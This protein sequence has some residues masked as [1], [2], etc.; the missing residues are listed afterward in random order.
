MILLKKKNYLRTNETAIGETIEI[1]NE[2]TEIKKFIIDGKST[3]DGEPAPDTPIEIESVG[4]TNLFDKD[5]VILENRYLKDDGSTSD[6]VADWIVTMSL[7]EV[8]PNQNYVIS[9]KNMGERFIYAEYS[10]NNPVTTVGQRVEITPVTSFKTSS[11]TKYI[12]FCTNNPNATKF[13]IEE[14]SIVHPYMPYI[15]LGKYGIE[16]KTVGKNLFNNIMESGNINSSGVNYNDGNSIRSVDFIK[17]QP[18]K[19]YTISNNGVPIQCN[20][21]QY[22][23]KQTFISRTFSNA[24]SIIT[25]SNTKYIKFQTSVVTNYKFQLE[26]GSTFTE[27]EPYKENISVLQLNEPLRSL[28]NGV[29]D[30]AYLKNDKLYVDRYVGSVVLNGSEYCMLQSINSYGIA[31]FLVTFAKEYYNTN[32][33]SNML[34]D[35]F[36]K[37]TT[38]IANTQ[39]EGFLPTLSSSDHVLGIYIRIKST[40]VSNLEDFKNWLSTHNTE[41]LYELATP[42]TEEL[43][44]ITILEL[45]DGENNISNSEN[46]N[47]KIEY[48]NYTP[49]IFEFNTILQS[50]YRINE[51]QNLISKKQFVNG[52]RKKINTSYTDVIIN[53]DLGCFDGN[54]LGE[55]LTNLTDG[56][57]EYYSL[58]DKKIKN[59][60]FIVTLPELQ[61]DNSACEVFV[62]DFTATL[63]KSS[64]VE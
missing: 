41:V 28:P 12:R 11:T 61:V 63:E 54:T 6:V 3:Q 2:K 39:T 60:N 53:L 10:S 24:T 37:Q 7:I 62:G 45:L 30:I 9:A 20:I 43:G 13:K 26:E 48:V 52:K 5:N 64:D 55:C 38:P 19:E 27:Y 32:G 47:M 34:T 59:A 16:V 1:K 31:N 25:S 15:P 46:A 4:Y 29:K 51:Q 18:N 36:A 17:V 23:E 40:T 22:D 14:G 8:K 21:S 42:V 35:R 50:G 33:Y 58:K 49:E 44:D 56:E 57:Y